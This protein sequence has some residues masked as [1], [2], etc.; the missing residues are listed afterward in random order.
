MFIEISI[1]ILSVLLTIFLLWKF[2]PKEKILDAQ[3]S[4]LFMQALTWLLGALVVE[5]R[6]IEYPFRFMEHA[7]RISFTFEYFIFP[8]VSALF[9]MHFPADKSFMKKV[10]YSVSF[11]TAITI[12]EVILEKYTETIN[13]I[14][15]NWYLTWTSM[16]IVLLISYRYYCWFFKSMRKRL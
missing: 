1:L 15:W 10:Q 14:N 8:A 7:Y 9:N 3:I 2:T 12:G 11:P 6:L 5:A 4:F 13:Y 16:F